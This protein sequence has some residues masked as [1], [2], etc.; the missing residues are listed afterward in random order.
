M[1]GVPWGDLYKGFSSN[2][3]D[4]AVAEVEVERLM[5][6]EDVSNKAGIYSYVFDRKE[7]HLSIRSFSE[8]Q[9]RE[10]YERQGGICPVCRK[11]FEIEKMEADHITPWH[12]GGKTSPENCQMLCKEDNRR[13][14]GV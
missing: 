6:D 13:K 5:Q 14:S 4:P 2:P 7:K 10:A 8:R 11:Q 1:K 9:K 12:A 3:F